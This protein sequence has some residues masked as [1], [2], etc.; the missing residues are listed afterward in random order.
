MP[1]QQFAQALGRDRVHSACGAR[2]RA[3]GVCGTCERVPASAEGGDLLQS[4]QR[5]DKIAALNRSDAFRVRGSVPEPPMAEL[6]QHLVRG[7]SGLASGD[8]GTRSGEPQNDNSW[9]QHRPTWPRCGY[10]PIILSGRTSD[11]CPSAVRGAADS[12]YSAHSLLS[13]RAAPKPA[14]T[15]L[16][17]PFAEC[18]LGPCVRFDSR[19]TSGAGSSRPVARERGRVILAP[20]PE[21]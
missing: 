1:F 19:T 3:T 18:P 11:N 5:P 20:G 2:H 13:M 6:P 17:P 4:W 14:L 16:D 15:A 12:A 21:P 10:E 7:P 8:R 9:L